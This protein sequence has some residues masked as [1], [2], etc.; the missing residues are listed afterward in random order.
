M[1]KLLLTLTATLVCAG[2]FAQGKLAFQ[3][4][5]TGIIY[6]T[7]DKTQLVPADS[8]KVVAGYALAGSGAYV[9]TAGPSVPGTVASLTGTPSFIVALYGGT[10]AGSLTL[11][12][13][14]TI[15]TY[16]AEGTL[17][18]AN[19][20][21]PTLPAGTAAFFQIEVYDSR[22][23]SAP[24]AWSAGFEYAGESAIFTAVPQPS[25]Y[26][27]IYQTATPVLSTIGN[28]QQTIADYPGAKGLIALYAE[29]PE[30]ASFA[31]AGLGAAALL[32][33]R[34]RK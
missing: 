24:A 33:F 1:K 20:T 31:L 10:T 28:G 21:F 7:T 12:T 16:G 8:A 15:A 27:N 4:N 29:V 11:Q 18:A 9:G 23:A 14:T 17:I 19:S 25:S 3:L 2:A 22:A 30:P 5:T 32:I 13:T 6:F 34:R 26:N